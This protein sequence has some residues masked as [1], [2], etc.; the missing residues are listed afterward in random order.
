MWGDGFD[1]HFSVD[2]GFHDWGWRPGAGNMTRFD[3]ARKG[4]VIF[5]NENQT[6]L[7]ANQVII[8]GGGDLFQLI[9][10]LG[11]DSP[12]HL[13]WMISNSGIGFDYAYWYECICDSW[14]ECENGGWSH[15]REGTNWH[16]NMDSFRDDLTRRIRGNFDIGNIFTSMNMSITTWGD[17]NA[18]TTNLQIVGVYF[19]FLNMEMEDA[20]RLWDQ[21]GYWNLVR[22]SSTVFLSYELIDNN[23]Q[24]NSAFNPNPYTA[25]IAQLVGT[26]SVDFPLIQFISNFDRNE[27]GFVI[28]NQFSSFYENFVGVVSILSTILFWIGFAFAVF[29]ALLISSFISMTISYKKR[30]IGILRAIGA[31]KW[32]IYKI[33]FN[34][35]LIINAINV[36]IAVI[37]SFITIFVLNPLIGG[38]LGLNV[39][40]LSFGFR[41]IGLIA[42]VGILVA[43]IASFLPTF[44]IN[45]LKPIDAIYNRK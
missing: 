18:T 31:R 21:G 26:R 11:I 4:R 42:G 38:G 7:G 33:F 29:S 12:Y 19:D 35:S 43:A 20:I 3:A 28:R 2:T 13:N 34:E 32:D 5:F 39:V 10:S 23:P 45:R 17:W 44:K 22:S 8:G 40:L 37:L 15:W 24:L 25:L 16:T 1:V 36:S 14:Y 9:E 27:S 6:T 30:E 41:Q